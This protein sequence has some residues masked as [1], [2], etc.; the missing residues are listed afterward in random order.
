MTL[1]TVQVEKRLLSVS[2]YHKMIAAGIFKENDRVELIYGEIVKKSAVHSPHSSRVTRISQFFFRN[3]STKSAIVS[4][5]DPITLPT[6][7]SEPEPDIVIAK[8]QEDF[9]LEHHPTPADIHLV[10]EVSHTTLAYDRRV[11]TSL[12]AEAEIPLYWII[13][14]EEEQIEVYT[15]PKNGEYSTKNVF[16]KG[17]KFHLDIF[18]LD[19][20]VNALL[21]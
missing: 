20:E 2:D 5:Q 9:Y 1:K 15:Q 3:L 11:K 12:Y 4:I 14:V 10:I 18:D 21:G 16:E 7:N 13:N 17:E 6:V 8:Y 19:I